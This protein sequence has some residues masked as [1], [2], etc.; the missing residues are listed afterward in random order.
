MCFIAIVG[1]LC[2]CWVLHVSVVCCLLMGGL[3]FMLLVCCVMVDCLFSLC[4]GL[5]CIIYCV[6][7][8]LGFE[9]LCVLICCDSY[10]GCF[11]VLRVW[12]G[13]LDLVW[14]GGSV[15]GLFITLFVDLPRVFWFAICCV[16]FKCLFYLMLVWV[17]LLVRL[18]VGW[19]IVFYLIVLIALVLRLRL[20]LVVYYVVV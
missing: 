15:R 3:C 12:V 4:F 16:G 20:K 8:V 11:I 10:F 17:V 18:V 13:V 1:L 7:G 6:C 2:F 9:R 5:V 19:L 14:F